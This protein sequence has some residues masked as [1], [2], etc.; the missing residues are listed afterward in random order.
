MQG[1]MT[2]P[3]TAALN[4]TREPSTAKHENYGYFLS[5][6]PP[7]LAVA[8]R[9]GGVSDHFGTWEVYIQD[10]PDPLLKAC[11]NSGLYTIHTTQISA[12]L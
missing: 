12:M 6:F 7:F 10:L 11:K 8:Q 2:T 5:S 3:P 4:T 9:G 1:R